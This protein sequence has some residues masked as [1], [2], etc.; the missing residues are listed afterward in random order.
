MMRRVDNLW[1]RLLAAA[2][3]WIV[4]RLNAHRRREILRY[5]R[6]RL[7]CQKPYLN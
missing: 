5:F 4:C 7:A 2:Y 1:F 6:R 3:R